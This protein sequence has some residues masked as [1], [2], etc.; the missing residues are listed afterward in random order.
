[1]N[2]IDGLL[3]ASPEKRY[4]NFI[5]TVVD[6]EEVWLLSNEDGYATYDD[7]N[8]TNLLVWAE[9]QFAEM[10]ADRDTAVSIEIHDFCELCKE[11]HDDNIGFLVFY[12]GKDAYWVDANK[13]LCDIQEE[14]SLVE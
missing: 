10:F 12:N 5:S 9:K 7:E 14:L 1:M 3:S 2:K 8:Y 6:H 13:I 11:M 4:K